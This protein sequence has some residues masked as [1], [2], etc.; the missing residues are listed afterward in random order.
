MSCVNFGD[1]NSGYQVG[2]N[3]GVINLPAGEFN[4]VDDGSGEID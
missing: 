4:G 2:V 3:K 1:R